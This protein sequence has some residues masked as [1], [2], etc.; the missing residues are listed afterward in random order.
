MSLDFTTLLDPAQ[1]C[2]PKKGDR[3]FPQVVHP[4]SGA[5]FANDAVTRDAFLWEGFAE[6]G[7]AL[8]EECGRRSFQQD[9]LIYPIFYTY[10]HSLELAIKG[11]IARYSLYADD[12]AAN[13]IHHDLWKLWTHCKEVIVSVSSSAADLALVE[14]VEQVVKDFHDNDAGSM[15]FR[16]SR[17]TSGNLIALPVQSV[18]LQRLK[19]VMEGVT[20]FFRAVEEELYSIC[21]A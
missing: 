6:A 3:L 15:A 20:N 10:R 7:A 1:Y 18:D 12:A 2:W 21:S 16:Y 17:D 14:L 4:G 8:V 19:E 5:G 11:I 9:V 13:T